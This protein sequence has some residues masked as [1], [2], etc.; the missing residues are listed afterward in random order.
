MLYRLRCKESRVQERSLGIFDFS[1]GFVYV[2]RI[3]RKV[4]RVRGTPS[5][6]YLNVLLDIHVQMGTFRTRLTARE[7]LITRYFGTIW[8]SA[9]KPSPALQQRADAPW[10]A[11]MQTHGRCLWGVSGQTDQVNANGVTRVIHELILEL[12]GP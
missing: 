11:Y 12:G 2:L 6:K 7:G 8:L 9:L 5:L 1:V 4:R 3:Q 10:Q